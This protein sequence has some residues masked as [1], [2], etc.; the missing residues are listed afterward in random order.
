VPLY[1]EPLRTATRK[2]RV[3]TV[4]AGFSGLQ[5]AYKMYHEHKLENLV[6]FTIYEANSDVGGTWLVNTYPGVAR[7]VELRTEFSFFLSPSRA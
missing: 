5:L 6:D 1:A 3:V 7:S 4:G 2:L